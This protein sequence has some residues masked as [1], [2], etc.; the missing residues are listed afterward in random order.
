MWKTRS[1]EVR[2]GDGRRIKALGGSKVIKGPGL[3]PLRYSLT[4]VGRKQGGVV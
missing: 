4:M 1:A 2:D 3:E